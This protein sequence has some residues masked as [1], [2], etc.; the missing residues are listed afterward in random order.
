MRRPALAPFFRG[1]YEKESTTAAGG[2]AAG[3]LGV[4]R[5]GP[6]PFRIRH[7]RPTIGNQYDGGVPAAVGILTTH[8]GTFPAHRCIH[9]TERDRRPAGAHLRGRRGRP[10]D[11]Q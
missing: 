11:V 1:D 5:R 10:V 8:Y 4:F 9:V 6:S 7:Q 2:P 3:S